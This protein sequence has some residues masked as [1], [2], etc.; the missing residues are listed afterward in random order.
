MYCFATSV[1]NTTEPSDTYFYFLPLGTNMPGGSRPSCGWCTTETMEIYNAASADRSQAIAETYEN[2]S[3]QV[4]TICGPNFVDVALAEEVTD[5][6]AHLVLGSSL[7]VGL[8]S[9]SAAA[10]LG[11]A[12]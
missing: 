4:N 3:Q 1:T 10:F 6:A 8:A 11:L 12:L 2:A 7:L 9:L 5:A